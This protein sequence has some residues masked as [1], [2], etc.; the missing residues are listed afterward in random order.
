[1][2]DSRSGAAASSSATV[3]VAS[4]Q[5]SRRPHPGL[6]RL[7][8]SGQRTG[9]PPGDWATMRRCAKEMPSPGPRRDRGYRGD[10][11]GRGA[12]Q[13]LGHPG[14][15]RPEQGVP[16]AGRPERGRLVAAGPGPGARDRRA[17][18][19]DPAAGRR[20]GRA[21]AGHRVRRLRRGGRARRCGAPGI[22]ADGAAPART[23]DHRR[24]DRRG[25]DPRCG[26]AAGH[27][28]ASRGGAR[29]GQAGR[30]RGA[31]RGQ[32]QPDAGRPRTA[33]WPRPTWAR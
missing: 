22:R 25:A 30:R 16:T 1:M 20:T 14:G 5:V 2:A 31:R 3:M 19:G 9:G 28:A 7:D 33:S 18:A 29:G 13:R 12:G 10:R 6:R 32:R 26:A 24:E 8:C 27:P 11:G 4:Y 21:G 15:R 23:A 17:G